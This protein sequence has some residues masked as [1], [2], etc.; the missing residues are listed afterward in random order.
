MAEET[1]PPYVM[2]VP[3]CLDQDAVEATASTIEALPGDH[4]VS[5]RNGVAEIQDG[6]I[7]V[8]SSDPD[9]LVWAAIHQGYVESARRV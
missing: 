3:L 7:C 4:R 9:F 8:A 6:E 5:R 2:L 1:R